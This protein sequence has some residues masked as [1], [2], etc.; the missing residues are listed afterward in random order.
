MRPNWFGFLA[1]SLSCFAISAPVVDARDDARPWMKSSEFPEASFTT[2]NADKVRIYVNAPID[3]K[4]NPARA[5]RLVVYG[6]PAGNTIEQTLGCKMKP[7]LDWHYDIQHVAA[8]IRLLRKLM[9][10]ERIV[11]VC[12][13]GPGHAWSQFRKAHPDA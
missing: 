5:T 6:L 11:L 3:N 7:G 9:P 10:G 12:P 2:T 1:I 4:G 8:Q 13:E